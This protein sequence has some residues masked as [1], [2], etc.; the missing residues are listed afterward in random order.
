MNLADIGNLLGFPTEYLSFSFF[1]GKISDRFNPNDPRVNPCPEYWAGIFL[2]LPLP[3]A[4]S[5]KKAINIS[6]YP[7]KHTVQI[8]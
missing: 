2:I 3:C 8:C 4:I 5:I 6:N 1:I 7:L